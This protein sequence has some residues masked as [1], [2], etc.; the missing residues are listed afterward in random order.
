MIRWSIFYEHFQI[1]VEILFPSILL[2]VSA[3]A[4]FSCTLNSTI[5][6]IRSKGMGLSSGNLTELS[7]VVLAASHRS[8]YPKRL[9]TAR[10]RLGQRSV[11]RL[12]G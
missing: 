3:F 5:L 2:L 11:R 1:H 4:R 10:H 12:M 9:G 7:R 8:Y 6:L